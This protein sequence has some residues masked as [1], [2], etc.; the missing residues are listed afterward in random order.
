MGISGVCQPE[1]TTEL[2]HSEFS[3][4]TY[5]ELRRL[6]WRT[7]SLNCLQECERMDTHLGAHLQLHNLYLVCYDWR[8]V[9]LVEGRLEHLNGIGM[10]LFGKTR[11]F[12]R[13]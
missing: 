8:L 2:I 5:L 11:P 4:I 3:D 6:V 1:D 13:E 12:E 10:E 7:N 9:A